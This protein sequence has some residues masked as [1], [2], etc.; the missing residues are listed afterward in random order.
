[1]RLSRLSRLLRLS[2]LYFGAARLYIYGRVYLVTRPYIDI[3]GP[4]PTRTEAFRARTES[5]L[6][7]LASLDLPRHSRDREEGLEGDVYRD[8]DRPSNG[9]M[10]KKQENAR[11]VKW[12]RPSNE[13]ETKP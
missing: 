6:Q 4:T 10:S 2:R 7:K 1:M 11:T 13:H 5:R 8:H 9:K 3:Y 12:K